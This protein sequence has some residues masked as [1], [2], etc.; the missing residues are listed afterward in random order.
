MKNA[1]TQKTH[2]D[3]KDGNRYFWNVTT[4]SGMS[5][6]YRSRHFTAKGVRQQFKKMG[7]RDVTSVKAKML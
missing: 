3:A 6:E 5:T 1:K 2:F 7:V 4:T